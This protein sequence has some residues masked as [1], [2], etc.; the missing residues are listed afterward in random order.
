MREI[1]VRP[2]WGRLW[3]DEAWWGEQFQ[4]PFGGRVT[5]AQHY[6]RQIVPILED[7]ASSPTWYAFL[8][9]ELRKQFNKRN[10]TRSHWQLFYEALPARLQLLVA[11]E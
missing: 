1:V 11:S 8:F 3:R 2:K 6:Y 5:T 7:L 4:P 10:V 9:Q